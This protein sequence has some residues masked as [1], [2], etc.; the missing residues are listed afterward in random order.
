MA[1][2][3]WSPN[4]AQ[5]RVSGIITGAMTAPRDL[6][7]FSQILQAITLVDDRM[8]TAAGG[9]L[10]PTIADA[11]LWRLTVIGQVA[12]RLSDEAKDA[13]PLVDWGALRR[14]QLIASGSLGGLTRD[15]VWR[16]VD[17]ALPPLRAAAEHEMRAAYPDRKAPGDASPRVLLI[18]DDPDIR[19]ILDLLLTRAGYSVTEAADGDEGLRLAQASPPDAVIADVQ[20]PKLDGIQLVSRL[21]EIR[22]FDQVPILLFTGKP[23]LADLDAA[24][25]MDKIRYMSKGDPK[26]VIKALGE[27]LEPL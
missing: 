27:M 24:L 15:E 9:E 11:I 18:D 4:T 5:R 8:R 17:L 14:L 16:N 21:R 3:A 1:V 19:R 13:H 25:G 6:N 26:R 20:M 2:L 12:A 22:A 10:E 23:P 7:L